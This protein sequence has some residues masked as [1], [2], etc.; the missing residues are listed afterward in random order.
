MRQR[1][2]L[3]IICFATL[4]THVIMPASTSQS[5]MCV[6]LLTALLAVGAARYFRQCQEIGA[7]VE[8]PRWTTF[9]LRRE[10]QLR[11][12]NLRSASA[13]GAPGSAKLGARMPAALQ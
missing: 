7:P 2:H 8:E 10:Q 9:M 5:L 12:T 11:Q 1:A 4:S 13:L 3:C 6:L